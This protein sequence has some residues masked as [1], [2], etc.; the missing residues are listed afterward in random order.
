MD[1]LSLSDQERRKRCADQKYD[2]NIR[3]PTM[4]HDPSSVERQARTTDLS[5][6]AP[7]ALGARS[8]GG[9][10]AKSRFAISLTSSS[11]GRGE[12]DV[13]PR[14][15]ELVIDIDRD[16]T[17]PPFLKIARSLAADIQRGRL[18]PGDQLP[19]SRR[20]AASLQV[21]SQH[22]TGGAGGVDGRG[23][24]RDRYP[25]AEL[26]SRAPSPISVAACSHAGSASGR[27]CQGQVPFALPEVPA[28][29]R[30]PSLP[31]GTLDLSSGAPDV[32]LVPARLIGRAY[33]RVLGLRGADLLAYGDP[34]GHPSLRT[35]LASMLAS[36]RG[37]SV[38]P[39][40]A[41]VPA[42]VRWHRCSQPGRCFVRATL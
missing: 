5:V 32:R 42:A 23:V 14:R 8:T 39:D 2:A 11:A 26:L 18:R 29:Y 25:G 6:T 17:F 21:R 30:P 28:A 33:R 24:A 38:G 4:L 10:G 20:L 34:E 16:A 41:P 22:R 12:N 1:P 3:Q 40:D 13:M 37:L 7:S 27:T 35:A 15:W 36:T 19:G 9:P 31:R